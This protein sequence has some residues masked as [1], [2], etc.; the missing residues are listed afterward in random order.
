M[1]TKQLYKA[2][3]TL[4]TEKRAD[5]WASL[6]NK[7]YNQGL[8]HVYIDKLSDGSYRQTDERTGKS[9]RETAKE[10]AYDPNNTHI[11]DTLICWLF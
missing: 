10:I 9:T 6:I 3:Q 8:S 2:L 5:I 4:P 1:N 11:I 7:R